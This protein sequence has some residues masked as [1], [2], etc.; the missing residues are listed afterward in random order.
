MPTYLTDMA[1]DI[2]IR[3]AT[4]DDVSE[5]GRLGALLARVHNELDPERF[6]PAT[7]KTQDN[8]GWF[9]GTQI[10]K[11]DVFVY[12]AETEGKVVGYIYAGMEGWTTWRCVVRP[13]RF[14]TS[15][16]IL[17]FAARASVASC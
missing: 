5:L 16:S 6:I 17:H 1:K 2:T 10:K 8:Y 9:L 15:S 13:V 3:A 7:A 4:I 14:T 12:V 11:P